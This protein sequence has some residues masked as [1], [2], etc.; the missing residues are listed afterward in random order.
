MMTFDENPTTFRGKKALSSATEN[1]G[2]ILTKS[3]D[4]DEQ[5]NRQMEKSKQGQLFIIM[6]D[7]HR[8]PLVVLPS[9]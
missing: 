7:E 6:A 5:T 4:T 8:S 9:K 1:E 2:F 3:T